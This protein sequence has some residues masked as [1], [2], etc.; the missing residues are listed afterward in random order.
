ML[1][2]KR[3]ADEVIAA[4]TQQTSVR[5]AKSAKTEKNMTRSDRL[6]DVQLGRVF[7]KIANREDYADD[8]D[9]YRHLEEVVG[10]LHLGYG[11][12]QGKN[13]KEG[14][15]WVERH[16]DDIEVAPHPECYVPNLLHGEVQKRVPQVK[17]CILS[18]YG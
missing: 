10:Q 17:V 15:S 4:D 2:K 8:G 11:R 13:E 14:V 18:Q 5:V 12:T 9:I 16:W 3:K 1:R 7:F 6:T